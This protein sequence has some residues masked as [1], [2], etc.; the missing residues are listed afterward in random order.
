MRPPLVDGSADQQRYLR[1]AQ[2]H[3]GMMVW[4]FTERGL[5]AEADTLTGPLRLQLGAGFDGQV[6]RA[7]ADEVAPPAGEEPPM[8]VGDRRLAMEPDWEGERGERACYGGRQCGL[9][10]R[11]FVVIK[12]GIV[13]A[14]YGR[15]FGLH[16]MLNRRIPSNREIKRSLVL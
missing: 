5:Q 15:V 1:W 11:G 6:V 8:E 4:V 10:A 2:Y 16:I 12:D 9:G 14:G 3:A 13:F 7:I